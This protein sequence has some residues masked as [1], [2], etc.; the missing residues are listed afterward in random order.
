LDIRAWNGAYSF[1][2]KLAGAASVV[3]SDSFCWRHEVLKGHESFELAKRL[4]GLDVEALEIDVPD[5]VP[6]TTGVYRVVLFSGVFYHLMAPVHCLQRLSRC[7]KHLL[8]LETHQDLL[9][10]DR[11]GMIFYPGSE[12]GGDPANWWGPNPRC[13]Y[14]L[15]KLSGFPEIFYQDSP[16]WNV[17][18]G[19]FYR[20][21]GI[22]HAFRNLASVRYLAA[23]QDSACWTHLS[24]PAGRERIFR[25]IHV[26]F[27]GVKNAEESLIS[28]ANWPALPPASRGERERDVMA[29]D[30][31]IRYRDGATV[32]EAPLDR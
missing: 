21:R 32:E 3:A 10:S 8:I 26:R 22:Y 7:A 25:P 23:E 15:L 19:P 14:E 20:T 6:E 30:Q 2:A 27:S 28:P 17:E 16:G 24:D 9:Y 18:G 13:V 5:I 1:A 29:L 11:P 31:T 4:I 12:M